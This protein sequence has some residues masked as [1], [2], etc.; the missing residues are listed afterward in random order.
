[1]FSLM[2]MICL[3]FLK[4]TQTAIAFDWAGTTDVLGINLIL[5]SPLPVLEK[6]A[7]K[8]RT[9]GQTDNK[10][11]DPLRVHFPHLRYGTLKPFDT[12]SR[13]KADLISLVIIKPK[14]K[15]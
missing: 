4:A 7:L 10:G 13:R 12:M 6:K 3:N 1:M 8:L 2:T 11:S 14:L 5:T 15:T 9:D